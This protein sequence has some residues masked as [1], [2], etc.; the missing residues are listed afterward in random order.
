MWT[1]GNSLPFTRKSYTAVILGR[2][3]RYQ[4]TN[5]D[6]SI[7]IKNAPATKKPWKSYSKTYTTAA[8]DANVVLNSTFPIPMTAAKL[9]DELSVENSPR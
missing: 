4:T 9:V 6:L 7:A 1:R 8:S 5:I 3:Y 2:S